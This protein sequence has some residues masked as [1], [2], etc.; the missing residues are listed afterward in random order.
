MIV[1]FITIDVKILYFDSIVAI[2][3][4]DYQIR[5]VGITILMFVLR[6]FISERHTTNEKHIIFT[7]M[8]N[9]A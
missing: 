6:S 1:R 3:I 9:Y 4:F 7:S 8:Q 2:L 5:I